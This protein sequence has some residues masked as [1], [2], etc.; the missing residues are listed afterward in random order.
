L[1]LVA[2]AIPVEPAGRHDGQR[3]AQP[4]DQ[5]LQ[6]RASRGRRSL[7][8]EDVDQVAHRYDLPGRQREERQ[9]QA[10]LGPRR[11]PAGVAIPDTDRAEHP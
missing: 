10:Q 1:Q 3:L 7:L 4:G 11:P 6:A 2:V 8:P 5:D 9:Q